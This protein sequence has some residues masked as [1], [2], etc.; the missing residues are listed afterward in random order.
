MLFRSLADGRARVPYEPAGIRALFE[1]VAAGS[2]GA[3][4]PH[5]EDG[6]PIALLGGDASVSLEP[7]GQ[8]ELS[9]APFA[10]L[11]DARNEIASH[12]DLVA[13]HS[14]PLGTRWLAAGYAPF[15]STASAPWM[16]ASPV[17]G[18]SGKV[19]LRLGVLT[20]RAR[21][22]P[23]LMCESAAEIGAQ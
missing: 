12:L 14:G 18:T 10:H 1:S 3:W 21:T 5:E 7:G 15:G 22:L 8:L 23:P 20:A 13:R 19:G 9:G 6:K 16:P 2:A 17:V 11:T 4:R